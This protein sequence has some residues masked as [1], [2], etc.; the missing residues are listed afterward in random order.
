MKQFVTLDESR[1]EK[2][3]RSNTRRIRREILASRSENTKRIL[4][5][6]SSVS[7]N[8]S[9]PINVS[10]YEHPNCVNVCQMTQWSM[11][12]RPTNT[13]HIKFI[14]FYTVDS[15]TIAGQYDTLDIIGLKRLTQ[16]SHRVSLG[17]KFWN[18][19]TSFGKNNF[20]TYSLSNFLQY[21]SSRNLFD[22]YSEK[23]NIFRLILKLPFLQNCGHNNWILKKIQEVKYLQCYASFRSLR[24]DARIKCF[25]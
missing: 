22:S 7:E 3:F 24:I 23:E 8:V 4:T 6:H 2:C 17:V 19:H 12:M 25:C 11:N 21:L 13:F 20:L 9:Y 15:S 1:E 16:G 10:I 14:Q 5:T 18:Q